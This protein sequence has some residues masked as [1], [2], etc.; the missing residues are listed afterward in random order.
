MVKLFFS[1]KLLKVTFKLNYS[2]FYFLKT[3]NINLIFLNFNYC[4]YYQYSNILFLTFEKL[5]FQFF[6]IV[7]LCFDIIKAKGSFFLFIN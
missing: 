5:I 4:F 2:Y 3:L 7:Y 6:K 1:K